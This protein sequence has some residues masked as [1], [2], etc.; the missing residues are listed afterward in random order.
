MLHAGSTGATKLAREQPVQRE[1]RGAAGRMAADR[2]TAPAEEKDAAAPSAV[3]DASTLLG[4]R[5]HRRK[6]V[7]GRRRRLMG[8]LPV[9]E[10]LGDFDL[11]LD[12][13]LNGV[14]VGER[15]VRWV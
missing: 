6:G 5:G 14:E 7:E 12:L 1:R 9:A 10:E 4:F 3:A 13:D 11:D 15:V 2:A 8:T